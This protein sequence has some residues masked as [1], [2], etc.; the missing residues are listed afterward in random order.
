MDQCSFLFI[1]IIPCMVMYHVLFIHLSV[2]RHSDSFHLLA[3]VNAA[4]MNIA[5]RVSF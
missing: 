3:I 4:A 1:S 2:D 5:V